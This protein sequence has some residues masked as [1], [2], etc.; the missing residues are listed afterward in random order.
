MENS[1]FESIEKELKDLINRFSKADEVL[2]NLQ[3]VQNQ[4]GWLGKICDDLNEEL[5]KVKQLHNEYLKKHEKVDEELKKVKQLH[6]KLSEDINQAQENI[7]KR[8]TQLK[9]ENELKLETLI[10]SKL[11]NISKDINQVEENIEQPFT[12]FKEEM[13]STTQ[14][15]DNTKRVENLP[16]P[17]PSDKEMEEFLYQ[18]L[19][20]TFINKN[21]EPEL[22][23]FFEENLD[24]LNDDR[25]PELLQNWAKTAPNVE[26]TK[27]RF[28][29][30]TTIK[31]LIKKFNERISH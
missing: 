31:S 15:A 16:V 29:R 26:G 30:V 17:L 24:K 8:F 5:K 19:K 2:N 9:E 20:E 21:N 25:L 18:L 12:Q 22:F 13:D 10:D 7:E 1:Q 14:K 27:K 3:D 4:F 23:R 11:S 28:N 6:S